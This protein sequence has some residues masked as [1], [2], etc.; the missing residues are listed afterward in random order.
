MGTGQEYD[1]TPT[2]TSTTY[3]FYCHDHGE[4]TGATHL[5]GH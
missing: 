1:V 4:A 2:D 5:T 3:Y